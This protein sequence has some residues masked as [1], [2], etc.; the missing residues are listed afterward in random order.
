MSAHALARCYAALWT[1]TGAG[2]ALALAG[3]PLMRATAPHDALRA[4]MS[5]T[6]ELLAHNAPVAL[7][8]LALVALGWPA[9]A[10]ARWL[11]DLMIAAQLLGHGLLVGAQ[12]AQEPDTWR[13]LP[14]LPLEWLALAI[15]VAAWQHARTTPAPLQPAVDR[16]RAATA[17]QRGT[18][19]CL[20]SG[21]GENAAV[22]LV[23]PLAGCLLALV[24]AAA[25][26]TFLV[27]LQ[28]G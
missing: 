3:A 21:V 14:H 7:W 23:D 4:E 22:R 12:L 19:F 17:Q 2:A 26:E 8:P 5:T 25:A 27:P 15:P 6:L 11:G 16:D 1:A 28:V 24:A 13:Y 10:G 18:A 9:L 20:R